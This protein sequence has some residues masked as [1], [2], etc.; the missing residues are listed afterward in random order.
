MMCHNVVMS[1]LTKDISTINFADYNPRIM[2]E[3]P[4]AALGNSMNRFGDIAGITNNIQTST[5]VTGHQRI[6]KLKQKYGEQ[7]KIIIEQRF[8]EPDEF[9]TVAVGFVGVPGTS[10]RFSYREVMWDRGLEM[11]ANVA[12]NTIDGEDDSEKL[13][14]LDYELSQMEN[15]E[16]LLALTGQDAK[17]I[18]K[19]MQDIGVVPEDPSND[20][21]PDETEKPDKLEFATTRDQR[22]IIERA[23]EHVKATRDLQAVEAPSLNGSALFVLA[24]DYLALHPEPVQASG[25]LTGIPTDFSLPPEA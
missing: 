22:L 20:E 8:A 18:K 11:A 17:Q 2:K 7:V 24:S 5:L 6:R 12:A 15:G 13:A 4:D 9:G 21:N 1:E 23:I 3:H 19:L 25:E 10:I 16:D 14:K